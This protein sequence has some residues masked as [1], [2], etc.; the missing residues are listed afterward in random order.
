MF[1]VLHGLNQ[2]NSQE[3]RCVD[4]LDSQAMMFFSNSVALYLID[5][6]IYDIHITSKD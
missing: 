6:L 2:V 1:E 5:L 3:S 4:T